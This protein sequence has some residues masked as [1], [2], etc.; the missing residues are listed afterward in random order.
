MSGSSGGVDTAMLQSM[1]DDYKEREEELNRKNRYVMDIS[2][3]TTADDPDP[4]YFVYLNDTDM[5][6]LKVTFWV[7]S[8][9]FNL[10]FDNIWRIEK[11][12][13]SP[14]NMTWAVINNDIEVLYMQKL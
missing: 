1:V 11:I 7:E 12:W 10:D 13:S 6:Q 2:Y 3:F 5:Y 14:W 8:C 4:Y 9:L